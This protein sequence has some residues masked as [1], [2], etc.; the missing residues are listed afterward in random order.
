MPD[1]TGNDPLYSL[2][3][4]IRK[5]VE[6]IPHLREA[7][8]AAEAERDA[9]RREA[10]EARSRMEELAKEVKALRLEKERVRSRIEKLLGQMDVLAAG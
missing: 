4:R 2:E 7:K 3:E 6:L 1:D 9:A 5:T 10:A 8:E